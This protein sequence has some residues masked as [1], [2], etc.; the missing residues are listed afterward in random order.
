MRV[1]S[2]WQPWASLA[3]EGHKL[4]ETRSFSAPKG[5]IGQRIGIAATKN[6]LPAQIAAYDDETFQQFYSETGLPELMDLPR[7]CILGT[8]ILQASELMTEEFMNDVTEEEQIF[9]VWAEGRYAWRLRDPQAF[10]T[11]IIA[12]GAQGFWEFDKHAVI[13]PVAEVKRRPRQERTEDLRWN[14]QFSQRLAGLSR[15]PK[16]Q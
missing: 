14:L 4:F 8:A 9:G 6:I 12:R 7:G 11:P 13:I 1:I 5:L 16:G 3:V 2:I 10:K 15:T